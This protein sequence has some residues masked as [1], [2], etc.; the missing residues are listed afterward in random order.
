MLVHCQLRDEKQNTNHSPP[1]TA[2]EPARMSGAG[3]FRAIKKCS[4]QVSQERRER[5]VST[6]QRQAGSLLQAVIISPAVVQF[7]LH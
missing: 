5:T 3:V 1:M 7:A 4:I 2:F 6:P